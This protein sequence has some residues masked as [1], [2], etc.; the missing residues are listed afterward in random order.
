MNEEQRI[1]AREQERAQAM[2]RADI[3]TLSDILSDSL[4]WVHSSAR[5]Q[6]KSEFLQTLGARDTRYLD[7][8]FDDCVVRI[9]G[10]AAVVTGLARMRAEI[11][12]TEKS[13]RNRYT[14]VWSREGGRWRMISWQSTA[15]PA[16]QA[17]GVAR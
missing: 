9:Y 1:L 7:I 2:I 3:E 17:S 11:A 13:L 5:V 14:A 10:G 4:V 8:E 12:G 15:L 6:S 16:E